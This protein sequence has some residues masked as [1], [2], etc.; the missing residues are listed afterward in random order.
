MKRAL[1]PKIF[2]AAAAAAAAVIVSCHFPYDPEPF[3]LPEQPYQFPDAGQIQTFFNTRN[4]KLAYTLKESNGRRTVYFVDFNDSAA[5]PK[6][7]KKPAGFENLNADS[8]LISPDGSYVAYYLT[9]GLI[10]YGAYIQRIDVSADPVLIAA[11]GTE[12]HWWQDSSGYPNIIFSDKIL[13][14]P[15][16]T[17]VGKT[18]RQRVSLSGNGSLVGSVEEIAPYPMNGGLSKDGRYLCTGYVDAAFY[19]LVAS[20]LT[21]INETFQVCNPSIDPD[22]AHPDRMMFLNFYGKQNMTNPFSG[23]SDYPADGSGNVP[24][25]AVIF[26]TDVSNTVVDFVPLSF[27]GA[28]YLEWQDPEWSNRPDYAAALALIDDS[29]AD[30][31]FI[32]NVGTRPAVKQKLIFTKGRGKMNETSTPCVWIGN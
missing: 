23:D 14:D 16:T 25:H 31:V 20:Q 6:K 12:P 8:P 11:I 32:K 7:L 27:A 18:Y 4:V 5:A 21:R 9:N 13:V 19:D 24:Q 26:I 2:P 28:G 17:G 10:S 3:V 22:S 1:F 29:K 15:L 30:G